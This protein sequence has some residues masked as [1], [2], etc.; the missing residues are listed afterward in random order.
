MTSVFIEVT[1]SYS[2][3]ESVAPHRSEDRLVTTRNMR[4]GLDNAVCQ[5]RIHS[6]V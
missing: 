1:N 3:Y 6:P 2:H 5:T 4:H